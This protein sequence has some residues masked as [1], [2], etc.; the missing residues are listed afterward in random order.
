MQGKD[1]SAAGVLEV[2]AFMVVINADALDALL[3]YEVIDTQLTQLFQSCPSGSPKE[4]Q[5]VA[6]RMF[7]GFVP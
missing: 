6:P 7:A 2:L 5:P 1:A 4:R 3:F